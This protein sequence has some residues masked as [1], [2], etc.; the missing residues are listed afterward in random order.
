MTATGSVLVIGDVM[1]D[2]RSEGDM[3]KISLESPAPV[4]CRRSVHDSLGGAANVARNI[5][6]LGGKAILAGVI[7]NDDDG[8]IL[9]YL[10]N[11]AGVPFYASYGLNGG[12]T[13]LKHRVTCGGKI[14]VRLDIE[15]P[16]FSNDSGLIVGLQS[17]EASRISDIKLIVISDYGKGAMTPTVVDFVRGM[18][19]R[20]GIPIFVDARPS[21]MSMYHSVSLLKPNMKEALG[22]LE[23]SIH[24]GLAISSERAQVAATLLREKFNIPIVVV[25]DGKHGCGYTDAS[26]SL[27]CD[28]VQAFGDKSEDLVKDIC[29]AGDTTMAGLCVGYLERR[30]LRNC[31]QF[32]MQ[33]AGYVV[34][35]Y[36]VH[37]AYRD[38]VEEFIYKHEQQHKKL[39]D[40]QSMMEFVNRK[41]RLDP[42]TQIVL[43]NGCFD[44]LHFGH[45]NLFRFAK[46]Q[47]DYVIV[48]YNDDESLRRLKGDD[49]PRVPESERVGFL[50][51]QNTIDVVYRFNGDVDSLVRVLRPDVLVKGGECSGTVIP[52]AAYVEE[53]GGRVALSPIDE[54]YVSVHTDSNAKIQHQRSCKT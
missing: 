32:A 14:V 44:G 5:T 46:A 37:C 28:S 12:P 33:A 49:R 15:Q 48:A 25:T 52:G 31:I 6:A 1:L 39:M 16:A 17:I 20:H 13:I 47:G 26:S 9:T 23:E 54:A 45:L 19:Q 43:A 18:A 41:R 11:D 42:C 34:Q 3:S 51:D 21:A 2:R 50:T 10:A 40:F 24:P 35:F 38:H 27:A 36:G 22:M 30:P 53:C 29:G 7:G 8:Q 4:V